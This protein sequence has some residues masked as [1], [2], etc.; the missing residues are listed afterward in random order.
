VARIFLGN[1]AGTWLPYPNAMAEDWSREEVEAVVADYLAMLDLELRGV[2]FNKAERNRNLQRIL[3]GRSHGSVERKH[4][5]ISAILLELGIP[6][7]DG[8]KPLGNY[9]A[10][11]RE[12][13]EERMADATGLEN[14][15]AAVAEAEVAAPPL[16][17]D[18]LSILKKAPKPDSTTPSVYERPKRR[19]IG[20]RKNWLEMEARNQSLGRA[21]ELLV[22]QFEQQRLWKAGLKKLSD[23]VEHV[24]A[25][26]GDGL[27]YDVLSFDD[28]ERERWIEVK[29]TQ[30]G[31]MTPFFASRAEVNVSVEFE[32]QYHLYRLYS[33]TRGPKLFTLPG[34]LQASCRLEPFTFSATPA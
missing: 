15:V 24:S 13:V 27:G 10:L 2:E 3:N 31:A 7:V 12:I 17:M 6:Y 1:S 26:K 19:R 29:T 25:T 34:S 30:F 21:G 20:V 22:V 8:Y 32:R 16:V 14:R 11:L 28:E 18:L 9:Q 4:Q 23:R 5:N 33:F